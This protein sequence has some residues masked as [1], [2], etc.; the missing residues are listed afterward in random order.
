[1]MSGRERAQY[2]ATVTFENSDGRVLTLARGGNAND[3][4]REACADAVSVDE[5]FRV[6]CISAPPSIYADLVGRQAHP[7][8][9]I[10]AL[11]E[12]AMLRK[13]GIG[14]MLHPR[15]VGKSEFSQNLNI[16]R[17]RGEAA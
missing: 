4:I 11:P 9:G 12:L 17:N 8:S 3:A 10:V 2:G 7:V 15:L 14:A 13:A 5:S 16:R 6:V 1:M